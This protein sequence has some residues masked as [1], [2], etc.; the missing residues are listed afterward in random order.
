M[1]VVNLLLR[2]YFEVVNLLLGKMFEVD[3]LL[4]VK[5]F[6]YVNRFIYYI[7]FLFSR[8]LRFYKDEIIF[9]NHIPS[10]PIKSIRRNGLLVL[11]RNETKLLRTKVNNKNRL[12]R[13]IWHCIWIFAVLQPW[14]SH[15]Y[16]DAR[17]WQI[18]LQIAFRILSSS[19]SHWVFI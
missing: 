10:D 8:F 11:K 6:L 4:L 7:S 5:V 1:K 15:W 16:R 9:F 2:K 13:D 18:I 19:L 12:Q 3:N 17:S 14:I